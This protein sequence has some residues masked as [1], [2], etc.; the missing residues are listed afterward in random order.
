MKKLIIIGDT[1][2]LIG[3]I[4][5]KDPHNQQATA[6]ISFLVQHNALLS[7]PTTAIAE[8]ITTLQRK[9]A[10]PALAQEVIEQYKANNLNLLPIDESVIQLATTLFRPFGSKQNTFFDAIVAAVAKQQQADAIFSFDEWY[11]KQGF[12]LASELQATH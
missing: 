2:G 1:D 9:Y 6:I 5:P 12:T 8:T 4:N 3:F 10:N 11:P 7:F